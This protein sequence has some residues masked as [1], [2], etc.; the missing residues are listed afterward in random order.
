[1]NE[2]W[3]VAETQL[4]QNQHDVV[5]AEPD[6]EF[7]L[8]GPPGSGKTN[9]LLLRGNY[10]RSIGPRVRLLTFTRTLSEFL[11]SSPNLGRGD[12]M[13]RSDIS[14]FMRWARSLLVEHGWSV[15]EDSGD[16]E[17]QRKAIVATVG[18]MIETEQLGKLF[19]TILIDEV[20]DFRKD[21]L[22]IIC[23]LSHRISA[24]G[25]ARQRIWQ[26]R[27][28]IP[29]IEEHVSR[30]FRLKGHYRI[31][32]KICELAD[33]ILP[34]RADESALIDN[35]NY[36][37]RARPSVIR[38]VDCA[39]TSDMISRCIERIR[40]Q[41]RYISDEPI[42]IIT[43]RREIRDAFWDRLT[44]EPDLNPIAV[45]QRSDDYAPFDEEGLIRVMTA[46]SAKGSEFRAVHILSAEEF[47]AYRKELAF[48]SVTRTKTELDLYHV[49]PL[50]SFMVLPAD[51]L[52]PLSK[53][54]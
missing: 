46:H 21:E 33:Q 48:T 36:D 49:G 4:D 6:E 32:R 52:P 17:R 34:P 14:T 1:M 8:L 13:Q 27:E 24:A 25:D 3:W 19:D 40:T 30:V 43:I 10:V 7:L 39:D 23:H 50:S 18:D 44:A 12:Q 47:T 2:T 11:R 54:F 20:Q 22:E 45:I 16:F 5:L 37:E 53:L 41:R 42:G 31:G 51:E 15:P 29:T 26:H 38:N 28:G 35:C 9:I